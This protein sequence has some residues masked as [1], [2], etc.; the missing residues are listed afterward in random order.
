MLLTNQERKNGRKSILTIISVLLFC[1]VL[2][3]TFSHSVY[4]SEIPDL[5]KA[6][7]ISVEMTYKDEAV[8]GGSFVLYRV[9]DVNWNSDTE[10]WEYILTDDFSGSEV[11]LDDIDSDDTAQDLYDYAV[12]Q[13]LSGTAADVDNEGKVSY[14]D[15]SVGLYLM[16]QTK[17]ADGYELVNPFLVSLPQES[18]GTYIYDVDASPKVELEKTPVTSTPTATPTPTV[19]PTPEKLPQTGQLFWPIPILIIA[20]IALIVVGWKL[21]KKKK[22]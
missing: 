8:A 19:T 13:K 21:S 16:V 4:A 2:L 11:T 9:A 10:E 14:T 7:S 5:T 18:D 15:L 1:V 6:G 3:F 12:D 20:G 22:A 17:A